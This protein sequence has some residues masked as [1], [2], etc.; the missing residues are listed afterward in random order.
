VYLQVCVLSGTN[1]AQ[2]LKRNF[3]M[4]GMTRKH[5]AENSA[6]LFRVDARHGFPKSEWPNE[7]KGKDKKS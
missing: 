5:V 4:G 7:E 2:L 6:F 3:Q 1:S